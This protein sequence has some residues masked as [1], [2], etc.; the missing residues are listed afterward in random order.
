MSARTTIAAAI[1][2]PVLVACGQSAANAPTAPRTADTPAVQHVDE[3][4]VIRPPVRRARP[5]M[6]PCASEDSPG[7]CYWNA[8]TRGN[9][10][11][12]SFVVTESGRVV[13]VTR[14]RANELDRVNRA[15]R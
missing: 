11:G 12:R 10:A 1:L 4:T 15:N 7:P 13:Y 2:A 8:A 9:G 14:A 3:G 6:R 5:A